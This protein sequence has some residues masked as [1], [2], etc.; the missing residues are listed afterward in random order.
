MATVTP[1]NLCGAVVGAAPAGF[2]FGGVAALA[3][4]RVDDRPTPEQV[5]TGG[6]KD[7]AQLAS[8]CFPGI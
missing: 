2:D 6:A 8:W 1:R 4:W 5:T 3:S 7:L